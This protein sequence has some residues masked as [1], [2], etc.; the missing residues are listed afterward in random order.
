M[1]TLIPLSVVIMSVVVPMIFASRA[2]PKANLRLVI[3][4]MIGYVLV[5][6][7]LCLRVYP[8]YVTID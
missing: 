3:F 7:Q 4:L 5:W 1:A 2:N 6:T 8:Q